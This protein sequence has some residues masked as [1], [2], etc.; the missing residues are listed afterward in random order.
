MYCLWRLLKVPKEIMPKDEATDFLIYTTPE[1]DVKIEA[2]LHN[3]NIWI[4]QKRMADLFNVGVP[5][6]SKHLDNIYSEGELD[7]DSTVSKMEI[8]QKEGQRDIKR[9]VEF[10]N[11]DAIISVGYR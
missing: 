9:N 6:V 11:L 1:G 10:Y 4:T 2:Y 3:E 8:V 5:A 7:K